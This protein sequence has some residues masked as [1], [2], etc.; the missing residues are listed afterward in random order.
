MALLMVANSCISLICRKQSKMEFAKRVSFL[1]W[2]NAKQCFYCSAL[3]RQVKCWKYCRDLH[4]GTATI[5]NNS[6]AR[7]I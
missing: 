6:A 1:N 5:T 4:S 7:K 3:V 2:Q